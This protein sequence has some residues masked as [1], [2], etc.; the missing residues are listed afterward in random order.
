MPSS[1]SIFCTCFFVIPTLSMTASSVRRVKMPVS[2]TLMKLMIPIKI[3]IAETPPLKIFREDILSWNSCINSVRISKWATIGYICVIL[4]IWFVRRLSA[5]GSHWIAMVL[6]AGVSVNWVNA[7]S[8][9][10]I[11]SGA[12]ARLQYC[13]KLK[14]EISPFKAQLPTCKERAL[15]FLSFIVIVFPCI[16]AACSGVLTEP[17]MHCVP[18][19]NASISMGVFAFW[20]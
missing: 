4:R 18:A 3:K 7:A 8:L 13:P 11:Y 2:M 10:R 16:C 5:F 9:T 15:P 12:P 20:L 6:M 19:K 1:I 14:P 17:I